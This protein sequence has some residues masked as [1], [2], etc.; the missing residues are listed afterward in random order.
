MSNL[1]PTILIM[2]SIIGLV[3]TVPLLF[4]YGPN[5]TLEI[6]FWI[7]IALGIAACVIWIVY[8]TPDLEKIKNNNKNNIYIDNDD[9]G[10][11]YINIDDNDSDDNDNLNIDNNIDDD[12]IGML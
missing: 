8:R 5:V 6:L 1:T 11:D 7:C 10:G 12:N 2:I 3:I 9:M 4:Y